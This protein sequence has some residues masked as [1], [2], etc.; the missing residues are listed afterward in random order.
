MRIARLIFG[1][2]VY[3]LGAKGIAPSRTAYLLLG[4]GYG[5]T[6][7]L[8]TGT[9]ECVPTVYMA[10][11]IGFTNLFANVV[12]IGGNQVSGALMALRVPSGTLA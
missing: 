12:Q 5:V 9:K 6:S 8:L 2:L 1:C 7:V 4:A 11:A 3:M 10:S